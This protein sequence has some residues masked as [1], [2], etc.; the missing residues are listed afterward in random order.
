MTEY[1]LA[2]DAE[3]ERL[4]LQARVWEPETEAMLDSIGIELR[5]SCI[6]LG[7][8]A[9]GILGPLA[10]RVGPHGRVIGIELDESFLAAAHAYKQAER[11]ENI[12]LLKRDVNDPG[13]PH[14][15]FDLV[16]E[17]FVFPHVASPEQT[18]QQ[19]VA[20]AKPGGFVVV[21]EADH[22]S[23]NFWPPSPKWPRLIQIIEAGFALRG[24]INIGRRTYAMLRR[25]GLSD[26]TVRAAVL[27]LQ[28]N[29][30]YMRLPIMGVNAM[31]KR[32]I[33]AGLSMDV[34]LDE[35]L[36]EVERCAS[37]PETFQITFTVTQVWGRKPLVV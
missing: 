3:M 13:L 12:E 1:I 27:A 21:Q 26:V 2:S 7:C 33:D 15:S 5:W 29:H 22:S 28:H 8:G 32:I 19:M 36:S 20:L 6:D 4:R 10:R 23:W 17:R 25:A 37:D 31:R 34:E 35:L 18:L 11:L 14:E 16:H 30:P 9:M 24:D